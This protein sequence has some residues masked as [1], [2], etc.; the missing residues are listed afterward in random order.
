[1]TLTTLHFV[2]LYALTVLPLAI[3]LFFVVPIPLFPGLPV[4]LDIAMRFLFVVGVLM[5]LA[6]LQIKH[7]LKQSERIRYY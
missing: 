1:M 2:G 4:G 7:R 6:A 3:V 5:I